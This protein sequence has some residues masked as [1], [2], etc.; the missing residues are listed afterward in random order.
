[1]RRLYFLFFFPYN[2]LRSLLMWMAVDLP[3]LKPVWYIFESIR[4]GQVSVIFARIA[5]SIILEIWDLTTI[6]LISSRATGPLVAVFYSG[7]ILPMFRYSGMAPPLRAS[8]ISIAIL[9]LRSSLVYKMLPSKQSGPSP[10]LKFERFI[11]SIISGSLKA[12]EEE[13][14]C[15]VSS[16]SSF[17]SSSSYYIARRCSGLLYIS[18][19]YSAIA[20]S[21]RA[22]SSMI[23][24]SPSLPF[25]SY[26]TTGLWSWSW[27]LY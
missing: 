6:G 24:S 9:L 16:I 12:P 17:I 23:S 21:T 2:S 26:R 15:I 19:K 3:S 27:E 5:F 25:L 20:S 18:L 7:T 10:L 1:M 11:A 13:S 8:R 14:I 4:W 22:R